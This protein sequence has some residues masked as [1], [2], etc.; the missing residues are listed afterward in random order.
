MPEFIPCVH[1]RRHVLSSASECPFC[2][3]Q[4]TASKPALSAFSAQRLGTAALF[5]FRTAMVAAA[6]ATSACGAQSDDGASHMTDKGS[7]SATTKGQSTPPAQPMNPATDPAGPV[8]T[9]ANPM[10]TIIV[11]PSQPP[12][13][14]TDEPSNTNDSSS[15]GAE[16]AQSDAGAEPSTSASA[17]EPSGE[18]VHAG[19]ASGID[20]MNPI[21]IYRAPPTD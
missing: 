14:P 6:A 4:L 2:S 16:N 17:T 15:G 3:G 19:G 8:N 9:A 5:T 12:G 13:T 7:A 1:C 20:H 18:D 11:L 10:N 21:S